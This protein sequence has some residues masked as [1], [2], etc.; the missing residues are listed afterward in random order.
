M[1]KLPSFQFYP[2]DWKKDPGI[3]ALDH[4][5][6]G[7]WLDILIL[8]H[9]SERR[10]V[11]LLNGQP[12]PDEALARALGLPLDLL[13]QNLTTLLSYGVTSREPS[14]GALMCRRMV[15]DEEL[16]KIRQNCGKL[17]GNPSLVNQKST[18][19]VN[20]TPTPS[21]SSSSSPSGVQANTHQPG[22]YPSISEVKTYGEMRGVTSEVC[23]RF[24]NHFEASGWIDKNGH[25]IKNWQAKL[26]TWNTDDRARGAEAAHHANGAGKKLPTVF[27]LTKKMEAQEREA[28][29]IKNSYSSDAAMGT[30]W[31][32]EKKRKEWVELRKS[33]SSLNKQIAN[34]G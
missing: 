34:Y 27:E 32:N 29:K 25:P 7:V 13:K 10:G 11:L 30:N 15:R 33:I 21:S 20:Q 23:D 24:W 28:A 6:R 16:R 26:T 3:Q 17:G 12:M 22:A 14:T 19:Q 5:H 18:T 4:H 1:S 31:S 2:G 8:M 9:E